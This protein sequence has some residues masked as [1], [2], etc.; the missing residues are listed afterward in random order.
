MNRRSFIATIGTVTTLTAGCVSQSDGNQPTEKGSTPNGNT[1]FDDIDCPSFADSDQTV[2]YH[3][4]TD[5]DASVVVEPST[6]QFAPSGADDSVE[7]MAFVLRNR[8]DEPFGLNPYS[9][10]IYERI[11]TKWSFVAPEEYVEPWTEIPS[12][13]TYTWQFSIQQHSAPMSED[14]MAIVENLTS[15]IYAFTITGFGTVDG[16]DETNVECIALFEVQRTDET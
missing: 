8:T 1:G 5:D 15:G 6:E 2:C 13:E 3:T 14:T 7:T 11:D 4:L 12:G 10:S 9:W 16:N